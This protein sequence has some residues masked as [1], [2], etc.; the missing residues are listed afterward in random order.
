[1]SEKYEGEEWTEAETDRQDYVDN[2]IEHTIDRLA[3]T[4]LEH[5]IEFIGKVRDALQEIIVDDLKLM[6]EQEFYPYR[7]LESEPKQKEMIITDEQLVTAMQ[8]EIEDMD[9]D[10]LA[11]MAGDWLGGLCWY[12]NDNLYS[13]IPDERYYGALEFT[14]KLG[15]LEF[16][17]KLAGN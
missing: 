9:A 10:E 4:A 17:D 12:T 6:T 1:M 16:I 2:V 13:F 3:G 11:I 7:V 15:P 5:N 8:K 14:K